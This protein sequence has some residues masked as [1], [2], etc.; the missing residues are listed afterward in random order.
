MTAPN[1]AI[2]V[3]WSPIPGIDRAGGASGPE[4][5]LSMSPVRA[6]HAVA[7]KPVLFASGPIWP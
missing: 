4:R 2:A 3:A 6:H 5:T 1:K 7:S